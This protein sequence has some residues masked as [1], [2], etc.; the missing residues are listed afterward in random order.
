M[1]SASAVLSVF[2]KLN[3]LTDLCQQVCVTDHCQCTS[4]LC[5][6]KS[7]EFSPSN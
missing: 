5:D 4:A 1:V 7:T 6:V 2:K 3:A